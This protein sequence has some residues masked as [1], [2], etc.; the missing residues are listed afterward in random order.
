M[1]P[2]IFFCGCQWDIRVLLWD[3]SV[4]FRVDFGLFGKTAL[5]WRLSCRDKEDAKTSYKPINN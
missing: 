2:A 4:L 3:I 5:Y 1:K